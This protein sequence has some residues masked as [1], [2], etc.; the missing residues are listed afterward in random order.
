MARK[1][2][3]VTSEMPLANAVQEA[4]ADAEGLRDELQ[5]WYDNLPENFQNGDK[6]DQLQSAIDA[7]ESVTEPDVPEAL[8]DIPVSFVVNQKRRKSRSDRM[9]DCIALLQAAGEAAAN[10]ADEN[11]EDEDGA[12]LADE[13]DSIVSEWENVEFPGMFS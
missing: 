7:L 10:F 1:K 2:K 12:V 3:L 6:G 5:E 4:F 9:Q 8:Q 13:I 11:E